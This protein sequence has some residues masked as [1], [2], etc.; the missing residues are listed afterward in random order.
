MTDAPSGVVSK[1][2]VS[3]AGFAG[4]CGASLTA[5]WAMGAGVGA[6][7]FLDAATARTMI[8]PSSATT[9]MMLRGRIAFFFLGALTTAVRLDAVRMGL[10]L[11]VCRMT[12]E[13]T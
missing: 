11:P 13:E 8:M 2:N 1:L 5:G 9:P 7:A 10:I 12:F 6:G 3:V 4:S